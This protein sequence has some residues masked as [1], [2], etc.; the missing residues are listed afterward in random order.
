MEA[1]VAVGREGEGRE[2]GLARVDAELFLDLADERGFRRL[3]LMHLA[4]GK[5][6]QSR[7]RLARRPLRQEHPAVGIDE[8]HRDDED[9]GERAFSHPSLHRL[10][11]RDAP[12]RALL[13]MRSL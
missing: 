2:A 12:C 5:F 6:P 1:L 13:T 4:A 3:A 7:H 11:V 8:R 10:M 9:D